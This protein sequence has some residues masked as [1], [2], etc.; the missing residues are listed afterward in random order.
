MSG[1]SSETPLETPSEAS[2]PVAALLRRLARPCAW[3]VDPSAELER[4]LAFLDAA[5]APATVVRAGYTAGAIAGLCSLPLVLLAPGALRPLVAVFVLGG[6]LG[7]A[8]SIHRAPVALAGLRRSR[9]LGAAPDLV[10]R[11]IL[12]MRVEPATEPAVA[13]AAE[14]GTGPLAASLRRHVRRS[15]GRPGT[16]LDAFAAE[17]REWF[18]A[19]ARA[20]ALLAAAGSASAVRRERSLER[21]LEAVLAGTQ[22]RLQSFVSGMG[23]PVTGLYAFGVLLPLALV[24][25][26]P[27]ARAAGV[28]VTLTAIAVVYDL[29]L[30]VAL[31]A[32]AGWLLSQRPVA[33]PA[34]ELDRT[35]PDVPDRRWPMPVAGVAT[36]VVA[37]LLVDAVVGRW[38][39]PIAVVGLGG[40]VALAVRYRPVVRV[41]NRIQEIEADLPD[42]L[43]LLGRRIDDGYAVERAVAHA[44]EDLSGP[45]G[46]L[47]ADAAARSRSLGVGPADALLGEH[48]VLR[49][50]PSPRARSTAELLVLGTREGRP[51]G[52]ALLAMA[53]H[54]DDLAAVEREARHELARLTGTLQNTAA[55][56]GPLVAGATVALADGMAR[57]GA[58]TDTVE[59]LATGGLGL[60]VGAYVLLLAAVLAALATGIDHGLDRSLV[61]YRVGLA[62]ASAS[63]VFLAAFVGAGLLL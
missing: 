7:V 53:G 19:L 4:A 23:G 62:L 31:L 52:Q 17:W 15:A 49:T 34:P 24:A 57:F 56:F 42:A 28:P 50:V 36:A 39:V 10:G 51:A 38:A 16:G 21:A 44:A 1:A 25:V 61:G 48:G 30:P 14:S 11:A 41:R 63:T 6:A 5:V 13:F 3:D 18:P 26:V 8:H 55:V 20:S 12:R 47:L 45:L 58:T 29:L 33:F 43:Y 9:A 27:G 54:L 37:G 46:D 32:I 60:A 2:S 22:E 59:T 40:G 35:H